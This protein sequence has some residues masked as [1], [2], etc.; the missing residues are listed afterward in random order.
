MGHW[1][2]LLVDG[3]GSGPTHRRSFRVVPRRGEEWLVLPRNG[4]LAARALALYPAQR[5]LSR[6]AKRLFAAVLKL[7]IP[8]G[9]R[10]VE[11][12]MNGAFIQ[13]LTRL[14]RESTGPPSIGMV[15]GNPHARGRRF[16]VM[17]F[18]REDQPA[19]VVKAGLNEHARKLIRTERSF[20]KRAAGIPGIAPLMDE[21]ES[22]TVS[23]FATPFVEGDSPSPDPDP[24]LLAS[25]FR[26]WIDWKQKVPLKAIPGWQCLREIASENPLLTSVF[27]T[28]A[29]RVV[30][31]VIWH[32]DFAPWNIKVTAKGQWVVLD[33]ESSEIWGVP[34]WNWLHYV[35]QSGILIQR[36][37]KG[38]L[39]AKVNQMLQSH[40]FAV[41]AQDVGISGIEREITRGYLVYKLH[42][43]K[44]R[45]GADTVVALIEALA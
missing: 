30:H 11:I 17:V 23:A 28:V 25:V 37:K 4:G 44:H 40:A 33:C 38:A 16:T 27:D 12:P 29:E 14:A 10:S 9:L 35:V 6:W 22:E 13:F 5:K 15:A 7:R 3:S 1:S 34:G 8:I 26:Q 21:F 43:M 41:Y 42:V 24:A 2:E 39:L 45:A 32:G 36:L 19:A 18:D 20:L 31:P